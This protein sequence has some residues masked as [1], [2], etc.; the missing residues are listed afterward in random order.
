V[1][2]AGRLPSTGIS[3]WYSDIGLVFGLAGKARKRASRRRLCFWKG[4]L[5][6]TTGEAAQCA[7]QKKQGGV[8]PLTAQ[9][10]LLAVG[11]AA[12]DLVQNRWVLR[13]RVFPRDPAPGVLEHCRGPVWSAGVPP[14]ALDMSWHMFFGGFGISDHMLPTTGNRC[15]LQ[16][17]H[18]ARRVGRKPINEM[19]GCERREPPTWLRAAEGRSRERNRGRRPT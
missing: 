13:H 7:L 3:V 12:E 14:G 4:L 10:C 2:A 5:A 15:L 6:V 16:R 17:R 18:P 1:S 9:N 8:L 11:R 19:H